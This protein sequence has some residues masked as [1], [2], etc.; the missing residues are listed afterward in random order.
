[1]D[2]SG[3]VPRQISDK[4]L[5]VQILDGEKNLFEQIMRK[6]NQR[7]FRISMSIINNSAD[8]EEVMQT[9][10]IKA[11][12]HLRDFQHKSSFSTWLI[13]IVINESLR[14]KHTNQR[15]RELTDSENN[16]ESRNESPLQK[17][18]NKELQSILEKSLNQ[19]PEKY[20]LVFIMREVENM[21]TSET[22]DCLN[23]TES[24]VKIRLSRAKELLRRSLSEFYKV[25]ELYDFHLK[26]C[27]NIVKNVL[28]YIENH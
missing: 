13:R 19:L 23:I 16:V 27:D 6:Y 1:M 3:T 25:E 17:V 8:A 4:E 22:M 2:L 26:R 28:Q 21:S 14:K 11:Y 15:V 7:L 9:S 5:I 24:N 10:Y 18:M 12:E 20:R